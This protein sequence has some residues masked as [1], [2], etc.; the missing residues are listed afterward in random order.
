[1]PQ[2]KEMTLD[3]KIEL[4]TYGLFGYCAENDDFPEPIGIAASFDTDVMFSFGKFTSEKSDNP[5]M[6]SPSAELSGYSHGKSTGGCLGE[7]PL[8]S[9]S[10]AAAFAE[11][12]SSKTVPVIDGFYTGSEE[13]I[14]IPTAL[15]HDYYL[16]P[17]EAAIKSGFAKGIYV[18]GGRVNGIE[19]GK[20]PETRI[21]AKD[22]WKALFTAA[23]ESVIKDKRDYSEALSEI[24]KNNFVD[25]ICGE[26]EVL[27]SALNEALDSG[28][29]TENDI[30]KALDGII[31]A[32]DSIKKEDSV[33]PDGRSAH[34]ALRIAE[35]SVV[36]LRNN[37]LVLPFKKSEPICVIGYFAELGFGGA[38]LNSIEAL[39][40]KENVRYE[41]A[42][43][44]VAI[45]NADTGF[46]FYVNDDGI[47]ICGAPLIN[48]RCL[49]DMYDWGSGKFSLKS[50]FNEKFIIDSESMKCGQSS[51]PGIFS[52]IKHGNDYYFKHKRSG[53]MHITSDGR[54]IANGKIK[55]S[56]NSLFHIEIFSSGIDR[57][58][59][60]VTE[61]HNVVLFCG[62]HPGLEKNGAAQ[63]PDSQQR[64]ADK[65]AGL[66][67]RTAVFLVSGTPCN[68]SPNFDTV[69]WLPHGGSSIGEASARALFGEFSPAGRC[70][71]TWYEPEDN[72]GNEFDGNIIRAES[73]YRYFVGKP[74]FPFGHGLSYTSF[75]YGAI[76]LN[77]TEFSSGERIEVS[78]EVIN[79]GKVSSDEVVQLYSSAPRFARSVPQK[80]LRAFKRIHIGAGEEVTVTLSFNADELAM[81]DI[82]EDRFKL[83]SGDY[84]LQTGCSS[85]DIM[86][87]RD[88]KINGE[89]YRGI[90][91]TKP[92]SAA[93]SYEYI[94][95]EFRTDG[96]FEEYAYMKEGGNVIFENCFLNGEGKLDITAA[97][98]SL[99]VTLTVIR[100]DIDAVVASV[101][102]P[103][104]GGSERFVK[105]T[106]DL[107]RI[108]GVCDLKF[109][110]D[111]I[112][113]FKS[114]QMHNTK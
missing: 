41:P 24:I 5:F 114:F 94:G 96:S 27:R 75:R 38:A 62:N 4:F 16:K 93:A 81:W 8:L 15:K 42:N 30:D 107:C 55:P 95:S 113:S 3:E 10:M 51:E 71:L 34:I 78:F 25:L 101:D 37:R 77:K 76:R 40:G 49:F 33:S 29:I 44:I 102:I 87:N 72:I 9:G 88:I 91:V 17:F 14:S 67:S 79:I 108:D 66:N 11:G 80:E 2:S 89:N 74:L 31:K 61:T 103:H 22:K 70:P 65:L 99:P 84:S 32:R 97:N 105:V 100:T 47:L 18:P 60:A 13:N 109:S 52:M 53:Y 63:I 56:K 48:E 35:E 110:V 1:M 7:D 57:A 73:T 90:D 111:G 85:S 19:A 58:C 92:V 69:M 46:Y 112:L 50:K 106:A 28:K 43:D 39:A 82:N 104:T 12:A 23:D 20:N 26:P 83:Y 98:P 45:R 21:I 68:I 54:I 64:V 86:R 36:L 6:L 59:R